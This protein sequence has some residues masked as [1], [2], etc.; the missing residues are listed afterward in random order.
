M[1][2]TNNIIPK[3][4]KIN[5]NNV[6]L[7]NKKSKLIAIE[8]FILKNLETVNKNN[9]GI[10]HMLEH[11]LVN[12]YKKCKNK[13]LNYF[14]KIGIKNNAYVTYDHI[15]YNISGF[16]SDAEIMIKYLINII[17]KI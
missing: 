12:S 4:L 1:N 13:C 11:V 8:C 15:N 16:K 3:I 9:I 6:I 2:N 5:N 17:Y 7:I 14:K 10:N